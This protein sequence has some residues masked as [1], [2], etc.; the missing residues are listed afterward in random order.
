M[1]QIP[2]A[3]GPTF[4]HRGGAAAVGHDAGLPA[5]AV[6]IHEVYASGSTPARL[7]SRPTESNSSLRGASGPSADASW[8]PA[9]H[10]DRWMQKRRSALW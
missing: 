5:D 2:I 9:R 1:A 3:G 6:V 8:M 7:V 4:L 10:H